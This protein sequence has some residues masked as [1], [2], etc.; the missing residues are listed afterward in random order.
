MDLLLEL[1]SQACG[2]GILKYPSGLASK[3][4]SVLDRDEGSI[5]AESGDSDNIE[6]M[7]KHTTWREV[8]LKRRA[9]HQ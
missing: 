1:A 4:G 7:A 8:Y 5:V 9:G 6:S 3:F 2:V